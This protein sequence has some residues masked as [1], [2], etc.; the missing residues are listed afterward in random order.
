MADGGCPARG[1]IIG[2]RIYVRVYVGRSTGRIYVACRSHIGGPS[3]DDMKDSCD[4]DHV[5]QHLS[6]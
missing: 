2:A 1:M 4:G 6:I 3:T 5:A